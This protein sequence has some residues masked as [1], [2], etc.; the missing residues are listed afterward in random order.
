MWELNEKIY[1]NR[2]PVVSVHTHTQ[3]KLG[4]FAAQQ[5]LTQQCK[6]IIIF[7]N[8]PVIPSSVKIILMGKKTLNKYFIG[9]INFLSVV[10][11]AYFFAKLGSPWSLLWHRGLRIWL[12]WL[13]L[14]WRHSF[15]P[16]PS[17]GG[18]MIWHC[19]SC[20]IGHSC[21]SDSTPGAGTSI[22]HRCGHKKQNKQNKTKARISQIPK[23][24][25]KV[26]SLMLSR[27][28]LWNLLFINHYFKGGHIFSSLS[29]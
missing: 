2:C 25:N 6:L 27:K 5:K 12:Q 14:L 3:T 28:I 29:L 16:Q 7:K 9:L 24:E 17:S 26:A 18:Y 20:G 4:N 22:C 13:G 10:K 19:H 8:L 15:N 1:L 11:F 21:C 23:F